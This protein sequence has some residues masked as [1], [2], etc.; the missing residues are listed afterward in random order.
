[1]SML[2]EKVA[3]ITGAGSGIG[4]GAAL[5]MAR[6]GASLI[7]ADI[8]VESGEQTL[9]KVR[10]EGAEAI[11]VATDVT[12][13]V[14][15][16]NMVRLALD[17]YGRLDCAFNNAGIDGALA[18]LDEVDIAEF[19][20]TLAVNL[21]SVFLCMK[22]EIPAMESSGG[23]SIVNMSSV[24]GLVGSPNIAAYSA[25]KFGVLGLTCSAALDYALRGIRI[26]A[27]CPG[28]V[29]TPMVSQVMATNPD[30]LKDVIAAVPMKR[31]ATPAE[32]AEAVIWLCSDRSS[33]VNGTAMPIDGAYVA[34]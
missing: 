21:R 32:V 34:Q 17:T 24:M 3:I 30:V 12:D 7:L 27:V 28:A 6:E 11:F 22:Y 23:G 1:M 33:F 15:V 16:E 31:L 8:N 4:Q 18:P 9:G 5:A 20:H 14:Q 2:R 19:D 26:N 10:E 25:S 29:E 13:P